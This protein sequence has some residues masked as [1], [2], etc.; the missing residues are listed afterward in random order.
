MSTNV[1][2]LSN[3]TNPIPL[4]SLNAAGIIL[5]VQ[6]VLDKKIKSNPEN[7]NMMA[8]IIMNG[9]QVSLHEKT[10]RTIQETADHNR[11]AM[12][13]LLGETLLATIENFKL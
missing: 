9:L 8:V 1:L 13:E 5:Q 6:S 2:I 11:P 10:I 3:K 7:P 12:A 4:R